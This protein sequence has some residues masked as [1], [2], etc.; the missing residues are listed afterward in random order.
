MK[1]YF[2]WILLLFVVFTLTLTSC[3]RIDAGHEGIKV[4]LYGD[5]KG[6]DEIA[7]VTG[8]VW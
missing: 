5:R 2:K 1:T 4:N 3:K 7:L 6:I 8:W